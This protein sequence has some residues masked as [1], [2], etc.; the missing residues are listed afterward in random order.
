MKSHPILLAL[1]ALAL[2][3]CARGPA[4]SDG[5]GPGN[6]DG[7]GGRED[8]PTAPAAPGGDQDN[9]ASTT[10]SDTNPQE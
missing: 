6:A 9:S 10:G 1:M 5:N 3:A 7:V 8:P 4:N 2:T